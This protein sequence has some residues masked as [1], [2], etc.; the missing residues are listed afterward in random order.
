MDD[1]DPAGQ[2]SRNF[3]DGDYLVVNLGCCDAG[4][5]DDYWCAEFEIL[6]AAEG[7]VD[8]YKKPLVAGDRASVLYEYH[9]K[10]KSTNGKIKAYCL[11]L[12]EGLEPEEITEA[13]CEELMEPAQPS[14]GRV[15]RLNAISKPQKEDPSKDYTYLNW[16]TVPDDTYER[17]ATQI[18]AALEQDTE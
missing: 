8:R 1:A 13:W 16:S 7:S 11:S 17:F 4:A 12:A 18:A 15:S 3:G 6:W 9:D 5:D 14:R 2:T 10:Y